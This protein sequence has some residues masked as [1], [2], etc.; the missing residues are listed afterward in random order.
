[1]PRIGRRVLIGAVIVTLALALLPSVFLRRF[2]PAPGGVPAPT[3]VPTEDLAAALFDR[4]LQ[5]AATD[6][7]EALPIFEDLMFSD[8]PSAEQARL[9][10]NHIQTGRVA[11]DEAYLFTATGQALGA[12]GQWALARQALVQAVQL[13]PEYAEAWAYL[14]EAQYQNGRDSLPALQQALELNPNSLAVQL[15]NALYWQRQEDFEQASL[16]F[17]VASQLEPEDPSIYI[18]WGQNAMLAGDPVEARA[19]YEKAAALSPDDMTIW[20]AMA[21]YSVD[22]ELFVEELGF[23]AALTVVLDD[24]TDAEALVLLGRAHLLLGNDHSGLGFLE[25][26]LQVDEGNAQA[27]LHLG[28]YLLNQGDKQQALEHLN[29]VLFYAPG[30]AEAVWARELIVQN[31]Q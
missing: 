10:A 29:D 26:A 4:G 14:G 16:H 8:H 27:H 21:R 20:K 15:F 3:A 18:Q 23:P 11:D 19:Q 28:I 1:M 24:E 13:D 12:I 5:L 6:P 30:S 9:M 22:A 25:R 17:Y 7:V 31:T 2:T